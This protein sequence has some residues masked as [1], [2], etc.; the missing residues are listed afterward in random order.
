[1]KELNLA[2]RT[3]SL[4]LC[5]AVCCLVMSASVSNADDDPKE[6]E[7]VFVSVVEDV[8]D[9]PLGIRSAAL[10]NN[11]AFMSIE[12]FIKDYGPISHDA[13]ESER[14][15]V[16]S[17]TL[18]VLR[19][20]ALATRVNQKAAQRHFVFSQAIVTAK[21]QVTQEWEVYSIYFVESGDLNGADIWGLGGERVWYVEPVKSMEREPVERDFV[22]FLEKT[23]FAGRDFRTDLTK[24]II[25]VS[26]YSPTWQVFNQELGSLLSQRERAKLLDR[27]IIH[28]GRPLSPK[29]DEGGGAEREGDGSTESYIDNGKQ[30]CG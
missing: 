26:S 1:M 8:V 7:K 28:I 2:M 20:A 16:R 3:K 19:I 4:L 11:P 14:R 27:H 22:P 13:P 5:S 15:A 25:V 24:E 17:A 12:E 30:L 23:T 21:W 10:L 9:L 6:A 18:K 29:Q